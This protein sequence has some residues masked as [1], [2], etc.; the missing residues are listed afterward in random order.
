[1]ASQIDL[2]VAIAHTLS[3]LAAPATSHHEYELTQTNTLDN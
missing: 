1:M 2:D 3:T